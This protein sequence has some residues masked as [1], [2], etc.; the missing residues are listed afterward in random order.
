MV[1]CKDGLLVEDIRVAGETATELSLGLSTEEAE[2]RLRRDGPNELPRP[3]PPSAVGGLLAQL[4]HFFAVLLWFAAGMAVVAGMVQ[5]AVAIAMVVV[6]NA[7]F[8]FVQ[9]HRAERAAERL[10]DLVPRR[11]T[12]RRDGELRE[13]DAAGLVVGDIVHLEGGDRVCADLVAVDVHAL[14]VDESLLSGESVPARPSRGDRLY[15]GTFVVEGEAIGAVEATGARTRLGD[16]AALTR[17]G[18]RPTSPITLELR[19]VVQVIAAV[20]VGVG[21]SFFGI[22]VVLGMPPTDGFLFAVGVTVASVRA[23]AGGRSSVGGA[24][25]AGVE[26]AGGGRTRLHGRRAGRR[27]RCRAR[28]PAARTR[29]PRG[30][31]PARRRGRSP[32]VPPSGHPSR[33]GHRRPPGNGLGDCPGGGTRHRRPRAGGVRCRTARR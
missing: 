7:V 8:A 2:R 18:H 22:A 11:A 28:P 15:A 17:A 31:S 21:S 24:Q 20:A 3:R 12:V 14:A 4:T 13:I 25:R 23:G 5:L 1:S 32:G 29:R 27:R 10:Q 6:V 16:I 26:G 19:R 9:E 30:P 33:D